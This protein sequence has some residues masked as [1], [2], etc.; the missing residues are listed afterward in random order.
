[1]GNVIR[2]GRERSVKPKQT[3]YTVRAAGVFKA[4]ANEAKRKFT[5]TADQI[6]RKDTSG[7]TKLGKL[8][9]VDEQN[10]EDDQEREVMRFVHR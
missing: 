9:T 1:M 3:L 10:S 5:S 2:G 8:A 6:R 7:I 4:K